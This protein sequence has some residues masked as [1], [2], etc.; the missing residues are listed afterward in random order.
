MGSKA[1]GCEKGF[2]RQ[3]GRC[4]GGDTRTTK[5]R[6]ESQLGRIFSR[7]DRI[8]R[9]SRREIMPGQLMIQRIPSLVILFVEI[10]T[11][12]LVASARADDRA[13]PLRQRLDRL[14]LGYYPS[15]TEPGAAAP[16][17]VDGKPASRKGYG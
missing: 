8:R 13:L 16:V 17:R 11:L 15:A 6:A 2:S 1:R 12:S 10:G 9:A 5:A 4:A 14:V 7:R 3:R